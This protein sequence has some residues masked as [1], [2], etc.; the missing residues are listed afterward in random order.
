MSAANEPSRAIQVMP[1]V[2][3]AMFGIGP[4]STPAAPMKPSDAAAN[5][6]TSTSGIAVSPTQ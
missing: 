5:A 1:N 4:D 2:V 6:N 3:M